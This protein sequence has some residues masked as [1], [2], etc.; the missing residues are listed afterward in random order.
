MVIPSCRSLP[1]YPRVSQRIKERSLEIIKS[2]VRYDCL[3][4][5][6]S[7]TIY[8]IYLMKLC[9]I[10]SSNIRHSIHNNSK[11]NVSTP[12]ISGLF[13]SSTCSPVSTILHF[14]PKLGVRQSDD[15]TLKGE[16]SWRR[17][18]YRLRVVQTKVIEVYN[19]STHVN[20]MSP[21]VTFISDTSR[22]RHIISRLKVIVW[23][24]LTITQYGGPISRV[25]FPGTDTYLEWYVTQGGSMNRRKE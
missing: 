14:R 13:V 18:I 7:W 21:V 11:V 20:K 10:E 16:I 2:K 17:I 12:L 8:V 9:L 24:D 6:N 19:L 22:T 25:P 15:Q 5:K 3:N 1:K 4:C 23:R